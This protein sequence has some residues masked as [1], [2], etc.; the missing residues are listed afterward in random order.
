MQQ[1]HAA[2]AQRR[3]PPVSYTHLDVYKRQGFLKAA[4]RQLGYSARQIAPHMDAPDMLAAEV[5]RVQEQSDTFNS[6]GVV[7]PDGVILALSLIH[8]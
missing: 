5:R 7:G 2:V 1:Q 6:V 8:I 4:E 3:L